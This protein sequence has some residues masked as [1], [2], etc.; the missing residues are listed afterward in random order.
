MLS[1]SSKDH[2]PDSE[3]FSNSDILWSINSRI[4]NDSFLFLFFIFSACLIAASFA[5][6]Q[7]SEDQPGPVAPVT[8]D[9]S[10]A[11]PGIK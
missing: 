5:F 11:L 10:L 6:F 4:L 7:R 9:P 1:K 2:K 3:I 8:P